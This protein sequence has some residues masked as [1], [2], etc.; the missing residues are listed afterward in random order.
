[1]ER[2]V[3]IVITNMTQIKKKIKIFSKRFVNLKY[4][5]YIC[6]VKEYLDL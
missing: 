4:F 6:I 3:I 5:C 1:M 2:E